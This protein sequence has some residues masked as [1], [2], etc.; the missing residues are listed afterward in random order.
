[1]EHVGVFVWRG[2][3]TSKCA[4]ESAKEKMG[5]RWLKYEKTY[6]RI[7]LFDGGNYSPKKKKKNPP[8]RR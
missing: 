8:I 6:R 4:S 2:V 1:M 5:E 3:I 7:V